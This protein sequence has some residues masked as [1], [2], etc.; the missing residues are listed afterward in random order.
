MTR[1]AVLRRALEHGVDVTGFAGQVA[2]LADELEAG[3]Q[4]VEVG[5]G[6]CREDRRRERER[7]QQRCKRLQPSPMAL[8]PDRFLRHVHRDTRAPPHFTRA[9]RCKRNERA[10]GVGANSGP[11][12]SRA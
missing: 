3:G 8:P 7:E 10:R 6:G 11:G 5:V 4:V 2:V 12:V 1:A 9:R